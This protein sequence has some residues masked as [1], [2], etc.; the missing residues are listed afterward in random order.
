MHLESDLNSPIQD[1]W[2][3]DSTLRGIKREHGIPPNQKLPITPGILQIIRGQLEP[4]SPYD[5]AFWA[6][7]V[8]AFFG[9]LRKS[10]LVPQS[11]SKVLTEVLSRQDISFTKDGVNLSIHKTKTIQF[12]D[13]ILMIPLP[14]IYG[15]PLCPVS[16][17]QKLMAFENVPS[18]APLF[19]YPTPSGFAF[20]TH[21]K[22]VNSLRKSLSKGGLDPSKY[23]GHSFRRGGASFA[24]ACGIP[25]EIIKLQGDWK[26]SAYQRYITAPLRLRQDL[27]RV[28]ALNL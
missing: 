17:L 9:F 28:L 3:L 23:S 27:S 8:V 13:R 14:K 20:V 25:S 24:F 1:N 18:S 7:C 19:S 6:A 10:S 2:L 26:S 16:A 4:S 5:Q 21:A 11:S 22:F 12:G 15:S